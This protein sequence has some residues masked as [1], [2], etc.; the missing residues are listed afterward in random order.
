MPKTKPADD[1]SSALAFLLSVMRDETQPIKLRIDCAAAAAPY[2]HQ[3]LV[4]VQAT[5]T[6]TARDLVN[7]LDDEALGLH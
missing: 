6:A 4:R 1:T 2:C 7:Q 5:G 3:R